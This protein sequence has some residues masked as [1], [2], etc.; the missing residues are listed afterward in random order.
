MKKE[1]KDFSTYLIAKLFVLENMEEKLPAGYRWIPERMKALEETCSA[2]D[3][4]M[5]A[6]CAPGFQA[7]VNDDYTVTLRMAMEDLE[8]N[9]ENM[10]L[11]RQ[12]VKNALSLKITRT[13]SEGE[14]MIQMDLTLPSPW[15]IPD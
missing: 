3:K 9:K 7:E 12:Y 10:E 5:I 1:P 15:E 2:I 11:F 6:N 13:E 4:I 8:V 14:G